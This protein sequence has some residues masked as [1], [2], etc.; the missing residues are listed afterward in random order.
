MPPANNLLAIGR[1]WETKTCHGFLGFGCTARDPSKLTPPEYEFVTL[2][3]AFVT[4]HIG[5]PPELSAQGGPG[6]KLLLSC[7]RYGAQV[8]GESC[9]E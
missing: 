6:Y 2:S 7:W 1:S 3:Y 8:N 4:L 5:L 9:S